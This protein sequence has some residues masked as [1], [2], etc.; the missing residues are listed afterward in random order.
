MRA[1]N[2][3]VEVGW[4]NAAHTEADPDLASLRN[5][6]D[7]RA[8]IARMKTVRVKPAPP[9]PFHAQTRWGADGLPTNRADGKRYL[10][11]AMLGYIGPNANTLEEVRNCLRRSVGADHSRPSGTIYFMISGDTARTGPRRALFQPAK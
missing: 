7:F 1:L 10:L 3:A 11:C 8:L 2:R 6:A 4:L 9:M 5:R